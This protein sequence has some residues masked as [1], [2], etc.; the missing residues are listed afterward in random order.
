VPGRI[1]SLRLMFFNLARTRAENYD[2]SL[3]YARALGGFGH[4]RLR[5][6]VSYAAFVGSALPRVQLVNTAGRELLP[7]VRMQNSV[8]WSRGDW[9]VV[10][11]H[12]YAG[13]HGDVN[14][15]NR[16]EVDS[17]ATLDVQVSREFR[18]RETPWLDRTRIAL[19]V[20]NVLDR[21]PPLD[22]TNIGYRAGNVR[23]PVGRFFD[24]S[25]KKS[26]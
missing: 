18:S 6:A 12:N 11:N 2:F 4:L 14:R 16:V 3:A 13:P 17:Y 24:V 8:R 10:L 26:F 9:G 7:R 21:E 23:R 20:A 22:L 5:S 25:L 1:R 15:G 19:G